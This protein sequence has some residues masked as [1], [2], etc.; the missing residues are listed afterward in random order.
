M[1]YKLLLIFSSNIF[2]GVSDKIVTKDFYETYVEAGVDV[3]TY[4]SGD[5]GSIEEFNSFIRDYS[6][7]Q[8]VCHGDKLGNMYLDFLG[9]SSYS[10]ADFFA[11]GVIFERQILIMNTCFSGRIINIHDFKIQQ[12]SM[13]IGYPNSLEYNRVSLEAL[14][15]THC[16]LRDFFKMFGKPDEFK[17]NHDMFHILWD[18]PRIDHFVNRHHDEILSEYKSRVSSEDFGFTFITGKHE[19]GEYEQT[20][21]MSFRPPIS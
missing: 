9:K 10:Y 15:R 1:Y 2:K 3:T 19:N 17:I 6:S 13:I 21:L 20:I 11:S 8:I 12:P 18:E 4:Y 14:K 7:V 16:D 5:F